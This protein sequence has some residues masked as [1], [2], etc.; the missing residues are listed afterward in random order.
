MPGVEYHIIGPPGTGK[1]TYLTALAEESVEEVGWDGVMLCSFSRAAAEELASRNDQIPENMIGT[2]HS[3]AYRAIGQPPVCE[4]KKYMQEWNKEHPHLALT[5]TADGG[6]VDDEGATFDT[7]MAGSENEKT[8]QRYQVLRARMTPRE[9]WPATVRAFAKRWEEWKQSIGAI[10]FTDMIEIAL[11]E[12]IYP[13]GSA[14]VIIGDE[15]Q[16][17]SAQEVA[18]M[19][20]WGQYAQRFYFAYD[21][22][23]AIYHFKGAS[24]R[25]LEDGTVERDDSEH[26]R[27]LPQSYRVPRKVQRMATWWIKRAQVYDDSEYR[28]REGADGELRLFG[29]GGWKQPECILRDMERYLDCGKSVM[30][31]TTC[32]YMLEPLKAVLMREGIPFANRYRIKR[33]DWNPLS[34]G[35]DRRRTAVDRILA[36]LRPDERVFGS[37]AAEWSAADVGLWIAAVEAKGTLKRGAKSAAFENDPPLIS[38]V[39]ELFERPEDFEQVYSGN[40]MWLRDHLIGS[41]EGAFSFPLRVAEMRGPT[42]LLEEPQVTIGTI[43]SVKGGEADVVYVFPDLS[44]AGWQEW[45]SAGEGRDAIFRL[46]YVAMTRARESLVLCTQAT[47]LA[48]NWR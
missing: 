3:F 6:D 27:I 37:D 38:E 32:A 24:P 26:R 36:Y 30:L 46:F 4:T 15:G 13:P 35:S 25:A 47:P 19:R 21:P 23:Q 44:Q 11:K 17:W 14:R 5:H 29:G 7:A 16:D 40:L 34:R 9:M 8:F 1:T 31:L 20:K 45:C 48:V 28:P 18:L 42:A 43:H 41:M 39:M 2:L 10:D 22:N 33:G 12:T